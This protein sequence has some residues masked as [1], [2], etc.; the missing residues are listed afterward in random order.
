MIFADRQDAGQQLAQKLTNYRNNQ[1]VIILGLPRGGVIIAAEIA[2]QL[3]VPLDIVVPR[4]IGHPYSPEFAIG[5]VTETRQTIF[6][7]EIIANEN[8]DKNY[9]DQETKNQQQEA[10]RR[11]QAYRSDKNLIN[12]KDKIIILVDDGVATGLTMQAAIKAVKT[13]KPQKII[14]AIPVIAPD[15]L[16]KLNNEV[17]EIIYLSAPDFF[18]AVGQFYQDFPQ[19]TDEEVINVLDK[20]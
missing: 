3:N 11:L 14:I 7:Q 13:Q 6:N 16:A 1:T 2:K 17:D 10:Q 4:K 8:I 9:L 12:F 5:A 15:T 18:Q 19:T 20:A